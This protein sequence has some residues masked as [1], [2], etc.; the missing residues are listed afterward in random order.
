MPASPT[1]LRQASSVRAIP[2]QGAM[3]AHSTKPP[4]PRADRS[5]EPFETVEIPGLPGSLRPLH[6]PVRH[7]RA[8][9]ACRRCPGHQD[10]HD[11]NRKDHANVNRHSEQEHH[12][13]FR[14]GSSDKV[15][16]A[17][18]PMGAGFVVN[19]AFGRR[20]S[21]LQTGTKTASA[22]GLPGRRQDLRHAGQGED[23]QGL[24]PGQ[25]GT[26]Y[27]GTQREAVATG[28]FPQLLNPIDQDQA[29]P[30]RR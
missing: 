18:E 7:V 26:P 4:I 10:A 24:L 28:V 19:F 14:E 1:R 30:G 13:V 6:L 12:P 21:T 20:G 16:Q 2:A 8:R 11:K 15:Y 29:D 27:Q 9:L 25:D 17:L 23:G 5:G 22:G 3:Q